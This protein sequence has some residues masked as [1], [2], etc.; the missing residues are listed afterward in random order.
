MKKLKT[1]LKKNEISW[2]QVR[3]EVMVKRELFNEAVMAKIEGLG[4]N[5]IELDTHYA[6]Y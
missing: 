3:E 4:L 5:I 1:F 2:I 6:V